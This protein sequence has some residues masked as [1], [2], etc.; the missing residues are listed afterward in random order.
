[1]RKGLLEYATEE[2]CGRFGDHTRPNT[3][4]R[5]VKPLKV[6]FALYGMTDN[7]DLQP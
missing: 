4:T 5:G 1:M 7:H 3:Q 2:E 6:A